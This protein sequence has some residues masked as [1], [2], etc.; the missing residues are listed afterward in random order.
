MKIHTF[1]DK[2]IVTHFSNLEECQCN[3]KEKIKCERHIS[4]LQYLFPQG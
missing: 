1:S 4:V 2:V 3:L